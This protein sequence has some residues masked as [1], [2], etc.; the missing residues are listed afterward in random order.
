MTTARKSQSNSRLPVSS[1]LALAHAAGGPN[2]SI[3]SEPQSLRIIRWRDLSFQQDSGLGC[4]FVHVAVFA[5]Q[6]KKAELPR[7]KKNQLSG[8]PC[9]SSFAPIPLL[10]TTIFAQLCCYIQQYPETD[11]CLK[12]EKGPWKTCPSQLSSASFWQ[13]HGQC[14][15]DAKQTAQLHDFRQDLPHCSQ[16][17]LS[18]I[19]DKVRK[20]GVPDKN[21]P[22][23]KELLV[24]SPLIQWTCTMLCGKRL[25]L[26]LR[27]EKHWAGATSMFCPY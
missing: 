13:S 22:K 8:K 18:A 25:M 26:T 4:L 6:E 21:S 27:K 2:N 11:P 14:W 19:V 15:G 10:H 1:C 3:K 5:K 23:D 20:E 17:A 12:D 9:Q 24:V 7:T 16:M